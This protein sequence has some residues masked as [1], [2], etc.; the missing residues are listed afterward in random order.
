MIDFSLN[1]VGVPLDR[2]AETESPRM[3]PGGLK[4]GLTRYMRTELF[5]V[6]RL[7]LYSHP[8]DPNWVQ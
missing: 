5:Y 6:S 2:L 7:Y 4:F 8:W 1:V 3:V